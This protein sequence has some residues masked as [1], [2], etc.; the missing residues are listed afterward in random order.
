MSE[1]AKKESS[2]LSKG[3]SLREL[4]P[5]FFTSLYRKFNQINTHL[6]FLSSFS[7]HTIPTADLLR[8]LDAD[9]SNLDLQIIKYLLPQ[10]D[11]IFDYFDENQVLLQHL[12]KVQYSAQNGYT[13]NQPKT[14]D[15]AYEA[16]AKE[17][18]S[19]GHERQLLVFEFCDVRTQGIGAAIKGKSYQSKK[20]QKTQTSASPGFFS[21]SSNMSLGSLTQEQL[22]AIIRGRNERFC[23]CIEG[24]LDLFSSEDTSEGVPFKSLVETCTQSMPEPAN[25]ADPV[26]IMETATNTAGNRVSSN[27]KPHLDEMLLALKT[28]PLFRDQIRNTY[29]LTEAR[30]ARL[31]PVAPGLLHL[32]LVD[33]L[34]NYK[35]VDAVEDGLYLHQTKA[36]SAIVNDKKHVIV[37]TSTSSGKSFIYQLPILNDILRDCD[38]GVNEKKR[39]TTAMLI[40]PTKALAQDQMRHL[41]EL[42]SHLP[43]NKRKIVVDTYD[44][45]TPAKSRGYIRNFADI[46][47]TNPDAI[48]AAIL[49]NLISEEYGQNRGWLE[50]L[51]NLKY[52]IMDELH[53]Y[54]GTFGIH[55][56]YVMARLNRLRATISL[57]DS[58]PLYISCSATIDNPEAHFRTL[59]AIPQMEGLL[60]VFEDGSPSTEKKMVIWEPPI[61][62]NKKGQRE[63]PQ[64]QLKSATSLKSPIQSAFLPRENI[65]GELAKILVHLLCS[66]PSIKV[67]VFCPIRA[68]CELLIKEVKTLISDKQ[69]PEWNS[70]S[71]HDVMAYRGGYAKADRRAIEHKMFLGHLR[72]IV[73]TNALELGIDL[74]DLDVV[75]SCGF[76]ILKLNL[77]Q[78]FGRAGRGKSSKGSLAILV[79]GASP[80]D[81]HYL[82]NSHE[83]C[84]KTYEDLCVDGFLDGSLNRLV[85]SM[86]LQCAAFEWPLDLENDGKWFCIRNDPNAPKK[87]LELC[88]EKLHQ[89]K[90]GF[91]RTDPRYLPWPAEK[92]S[93]RAI[94]QTMYAVVD[95]T[96]NRNIVIE[97]VEELRTSFTLYEGGIFLHQGLPY[98]VK[99]FNTDGRYAK[100][101]R[102]KVSWTTQQRDFSDVDPMEIEM[103][104]QLNINKNAAPTD[105]PVFYGKVQ[106]MIIV[107]GYFKVNRKS[108]ILEAVEVKNPPVILKSKGFWIDIPSR[109]VDIIKEK[110]LNPAGGIHAAQHAIM[111]V[112]PLY[113]TGGATTN[114]NARWTPNGADAELS[115]ECKAP[116]KEF[117][118]RQSMR[119]RP[120]RLIF[121]DSKGGEQGTGMSGKT[122]EY[123]DEIVCATYERVRDCECA[124]GCP[125]C[126]AGTFC[127]ENMLVMS[128]PGAVIILGT[129][130]GVDAEELKSSVPD[131]PEPNMPST[132][133]ET[134]SKGEQIVK[135]SPD[136]QIVAVKKAKREP[137]VIK[138]ESNDI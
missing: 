2:S 73:A 13:Q 48:H 103:V 5:L 71:E 6:T 62:M 86:H 30:T 16:L 111:N 116:E 92:V 55:V 136:V 128:K 68:V 69:H 80:I 1:N 51:S 9:I 52:V 120:A 50:F 53:V 49:P 12:E 32:D 95:I 97:E 26:T 117:A 75:V 39:T 109:A 57:N 138:Q 129:L 58:V 60:H 38:S 122:F 7:R 21:T 121:Y 70:L 3:T 37:S 25:L 134:I 11:V 114:P 78:Q 34:W 105:I 24:Y 133:T 93:L 83:L 29:T 28:A 64:A 118:R 40:F 79:C 115:T 90:K 72:A 42:I 54:K 81:R 41:R 107:F 137:L 46:I 43:Q 89:D 45:D 47:F 125:L 15:D 63:L 135:F 44:G 110:R 8:K 77:H 35:G 119:K 106:T 66:L 104:K 94:E 31:E 108:D 27:E 88:T 132:G 18:E 131:G 20:R 74:S 65:V 84:D 14:V 56:L 23:A 127:K 61:L 101:E 85:M 124:W 98:L 67:I 123:I 22:L 96:D 102:V 36:I 59:C 126:V 76:P 100:V 91:Y 113:V 112:L 130:L 17:A 10:G 82:K 99:D 87:F 33:A 4:W 19:P